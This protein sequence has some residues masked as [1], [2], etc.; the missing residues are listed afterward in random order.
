MPIPRDIER[1]I[2]CTRGGEGVAFRGK[3]YPVSVVEVKDVVGAGDSFFAA[4]LVRYA[5]TEDI[6]ESIAFAN[7]C[8]SQVVKK[9]GVSVITRPKAPLNDRK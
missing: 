1:K 6:G 3:T 5:E 7:L 8:A 4:L 2:I 9:K